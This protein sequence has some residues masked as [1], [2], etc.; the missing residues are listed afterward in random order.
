[1]YMFPAAIPQASGQW[2]CDAAAVTVVRLVRGSR[3]TWASWRVCGQC[4]ARAGAGK[5][6]AGEPEG[7]VG[8]DT[9]YACSSRTAALEGAAVSVYS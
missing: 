8:G 3:G 4:A 1:M 5:A 2:Q 9:G 7:P 6:D